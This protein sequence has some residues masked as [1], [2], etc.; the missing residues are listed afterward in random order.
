MSY[1]EILNRGIY[2]EK[3][4]AFLNTFEEN[5]ST[6]SQIKRGL[7]LYGKAGI[8]KTT[9]IKNILND[10]GFDMVYYD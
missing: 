3:I 8:G 10:K 6:L 1:D 9:F 2:R 4:E 7:Y 5:K